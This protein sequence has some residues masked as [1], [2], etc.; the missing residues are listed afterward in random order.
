M[1]CGME[2]RLVPSR[3]I[4]DLRITTAPYPTPRSETTHVLSGVNLI[5]PRKQLRIEHYRERGN[6]PHP[7]LLLLPPPVST[8]KISKPNGF[9]PFFYA[10]LCAPKTAAA[11]GPDRPPPTSH[12]ST[13]TDR[14]IIGSNASPTNPTPLSAPQ[15]QQ[16]KDLYYKNV[17]AK[18][19]G[20]IESI[21]LR[22]M[23]DVQTT[24][25]NKSNQALHN[26]PLVAPSP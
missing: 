2:P 22:P 19:A 23:L 12:A 11:N 9:F 20:E 1:T 13:M 25:T 5:S 3:W 10:V 8:Y 14:M 21:W 26:A 15:E 16:V 18:C 17:R 7:F 4:S 6:P 24:Q